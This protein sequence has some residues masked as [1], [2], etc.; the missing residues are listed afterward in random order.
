MKK[1]SGYFLITDKQELSPSVHKLTIKADEISAEASPGQ[2][3]QIRA[4]ESYFPFWPRPFSIHDTDLNAGEFSIIFKVFGCGT[5]LLATKSA[6][7]KI[8]VFGPL[9]NSFPPPSENDKSIFVAGG[10][11]LP[12]LHFLAKKSIANGINPQ[13][14]IFIAGA[15]T[16]NDFF[17]QENLSGLG[18]KLLMT[19][20]D[21]S[22]GAAGTAT[23]IFVEILKEEENPCVYSCGPTAMLS[24]VDSILK[25]AKKRGFL[26]LEA[27]MPCGYGICSG[28]AV[29]TYPPADVGPTDDRRNF[30]LKRVCCDGPV[31]NSGEVIWD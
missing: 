15:R 29:K 16:K 23:D 6:G 17:E 30:R 31:F 1:Y 13:S 27:L 24:K 11:G 21:G 7:Q 25:L 19:T 14:I 8:H 3:V 2:F 12:P 18:V 22:L 5:S 28:C 26:S 10:V 4:S 20:D 9:G